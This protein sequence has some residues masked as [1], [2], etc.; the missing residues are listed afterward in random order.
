MDSLNRALPVA[1][2]GTS[3]LRA[4]A[5]GNQVPRTLR[6]RHEVIAVG[7]ARQFKLGNQE[8]A[9]ILQNM[10][11][12]SPDAPFRRTGKDAFDAMKLMQSLGE[13]AS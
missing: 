3:P 7:N 13:S 6:S 2:A 9:S 11:S 5:L 4:V 12:L 1:E 8:T 10:Y